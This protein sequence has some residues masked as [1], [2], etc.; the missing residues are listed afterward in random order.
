MALAPLAYD[1]LLGID[2]LSFLIF[3]LLFV[4]AEHWNSNLLVPYKEDI[5]YFVKCSSR[6]LAKLCVQHGGRGAWMLEL[7]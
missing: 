6:V 2:C 3:F 5:F 7:E 1:N 4:F